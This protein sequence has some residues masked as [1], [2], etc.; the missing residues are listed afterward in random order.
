VY[1]F[2][3]PDRTLGGHGEP[4]G[5]AGPMWSGRT[6]VVVLLIAAGFLAL[7]SEILVGSIQGFIDSFGL[8][9]YFVGVILIPTIGNLAEHL[10]AVQLAAKD[11]ME[12][13]MAVSFGSSLQVALFVAPVLVLLGLVIGQPMDLVFQPLEVA[14]VAAAVGISALIALDGESN[15]LEGALLV[16]V[17]VI[18]AISFFEFV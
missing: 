15:W 8:T 12:F 3:N 7:L 1:Q 11:K 18:L 4:A 2:T 9:P 13:A 10:V 17:Y 14:A 6:A 5:H 16:I